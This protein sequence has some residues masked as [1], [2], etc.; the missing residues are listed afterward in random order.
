MPIHLSAQQGR[1]LAMRRAA[2]TDGVLRRSD[3]RRWGV[4]RWVVKAELRAGR[5]QR[6][7]RQTVVVHNGPLGTAARRRVAVAEI[8][9]QAALA[10]VTALQHLGVEMLTDTRIHVII[11]KG[12]SPRRR[13]RGVTIHE[14]RR[15]RPEDVAI[16]RGVR[17]VAA[18]PA[19]VHAALWA[20]T[21]RE[22]VYVL[23]LVVQQRRATP[24]E[25]DGSLQHV[26]R[27]ARR[28]L[29]ARTVAELAGG[30]RS[31]GELEV[32]AGLRRR[33]LPEPD[34]QV[35]RERPDGREYLDC[36]F[37]AYDLTL[38]IDGP[39]HDDPHH[40]LADLLRDLRQVGEG[41]TVLRIPLVAWRLGSEQV[42]DRL[43]SVFV[44]RGWRR[45]AA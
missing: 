18:A 3:L 27:H 35:L 15:Y 6:T 17:C 13:L 28:R 5:W 10:G 32:A 38:E 29:L 12:S 4:P 14:S 7:G 43:E 31:M 24:A 2:T 8:G 41:S 21:D 16:R 11:P 34:R 20:R 39:Q 19:A 45:P 44:A 37:Q 22:A 1:R 40:Q 33:S 25:V 9:P 36:R 42:L 26:R 30:V 23:V